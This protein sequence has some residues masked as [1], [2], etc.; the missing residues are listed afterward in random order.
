M[1]VLDLNNK[2]YVY[3]SGKMAEIECGVFSILDENTKVI[4][5]FNANEWKRVE[6]LND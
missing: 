3:K 2:Y 5:I 1:R 4:A 6:S